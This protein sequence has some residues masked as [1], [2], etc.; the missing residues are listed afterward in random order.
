MDGFRTEPGTSEAVQNLQELYHK[1]KPIKLECTKTGFHIMRCMFV[2]EKV[3]ST[4]ELMPIVFKISIDH[5]KKFCD[6]LMYF[7]KN[8]KILSVICVRRI[9]QN[10]L[11]AT[12]FFEYLN[13]FSN[14]I[15][16]VII[17]VS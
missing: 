7:M 8:Y 2:G 5:M 12:A 11:Y 17:K 6:K 16:R 15:F 9:T 14:K 13:T 1:Y 4:F 10:I 3:S